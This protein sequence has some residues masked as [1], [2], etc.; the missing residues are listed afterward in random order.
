MTQQAPHY[1]WERKIMADAALSDDLMLQECATERRASVSVD[2]PGDMWR[3]AEHL[4]A[5]A[6]LRSHA[7]ARRVLVLSGWGIE[8]FILPD[9]RRQIFSFA[10]PGDE[11]SICEEAKRDTARSFTAITR[12]EL[13][14]VRHLPARDSDKGRGQAE[15]AEENA[16]DRLFDHI[17]RIGCLTS[18]ERLLHLLNEFHHRL[19]PLGLV[20]DG[21]FRLPLTQQMIGDALGLSVVHINRLIHA[22]KAEG[23]AT[24]KGGSVTLGA[25]GRARISALHG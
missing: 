13:V 2:R 14:D 10:L 20:R 9:G 21:S 11:V 16:R 6:S 5:G 4:P 17:L 1:A 24:F 7:A 8:A 3:K 22:L 12:L 19:D 23:L 25:A 18:K 15:R